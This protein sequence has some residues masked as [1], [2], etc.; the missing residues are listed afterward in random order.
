MGSATD[1][2]S[3]FLMGTEGARGYSRGGRI[4]TDDNLYLEF[5]APRSIG[6]NELESAN[7]QALVGHREAILTYLRRPE[8]EAERGKQQEAWAGN[9]QAAVLYDQ[10]HVLNLAGRAGAP[11]YVTL[12]ALLD[13]RFPRY[14]P[15]RFLKYEMP[16][17]PGGMPEVLDRLSLAVVGEAGE[18][19]QVQ[20]A[21]VLVPGG[22]DRVTIYFADDTTR[23]VFGKL[24]ARGPAD[25]APLAAVAGKVTSGIQALY[26]A[27]RV[28][29]ARNGA[30]MP[31]AR[32]LF[33]KIRDLIETEV[34]EA[35]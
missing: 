11:E 2:L 15:W 24:R 30:P 25:A 12:S 18:T 17:G 9:L 20:F 10:A 23:T 16:E 6:R 8:L 34:D 32:S 29:A 1:F 14:A 28:M 3:Y 31:S 26:E 27:E 19:I 4:N 33:P 35:E 21:A 5:S 13:A 22:E 7:V